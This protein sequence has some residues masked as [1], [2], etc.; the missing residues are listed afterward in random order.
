MTVGLPLVFIID[1]IP[2]YNRICDLSS[3]QPLP[4][5]SGVFISIAPAFFSFAKSRISNPCIGP[6][7]MAGS[8]CPAQRP[9]G[10]ADQGPPSFTQNTQGSVAAPTFL[11]ADRLLPCTPPPHFCARGR[12]AIGCSFVNKSAGGRRGRG[13]PF[14]PP[15]GLRVGARRW[16]LCSLCPKHCPDVVV[17]AT[18]LD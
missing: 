3:S 17:V 1:Y 10:A 13:W 14:R 16:S 7:R 9:S 15:P 12:W 4:I 11:S 2:G 6:P 8:P 18:S 5:K